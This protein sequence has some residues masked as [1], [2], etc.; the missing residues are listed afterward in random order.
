MAENFLQYGSTSKKIPPG[1][2]S[3]M[4]AEIFSNSAV[5]TIR[6]NKNH[7]QKRYEIKFSSLNLK[8]NQSC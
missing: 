6:I 8:K 3:A 5:S 1:A 2:F 7:N 4:P